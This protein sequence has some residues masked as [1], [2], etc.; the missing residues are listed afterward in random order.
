MHFRYNFTQPET[1]H[2]YRFRFGICVQ[3][4]KIQTRQIQTLVERIEILCKLCNKR[5]PIQNV[6]F[7]ERP[8]TVTVS[9]FF[10]FLFLSFSCQMDTMNDCY[11]LFLPAIFP[12]LLTATGS[13]LANFP[14]K[15]T[16]LGKIFVLHYQ[17]S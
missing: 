10:L 8:L 5:V 11:F 3:T 14:T 6:L 7:A 15:Q 12:S 4:D 2:C 17:M 13:V 16:N 9:S 1:V